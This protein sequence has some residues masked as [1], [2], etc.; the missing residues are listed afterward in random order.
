MYITL[1]TTFTSTCYILTNKCCT[2]L[3]MTRHINRRNLQEKGGRQRE[4]KTDREKERKKERKK[5]YWEK[6]VTKVVIKYMYITLNTT[7][8]S[9]CYIL[10]NKCCT[11][12]RMTRHINRRNLQ[13]KRGGKRERKTDSEKERKTERK[14]E[15]KKERDWDKTVTKMVIKYMYITLN[16]TFTSTCYILTNKCCTWLRMTRHINR[17]NLQEKGRR[18]RETKTDREKERK[19]ER[20]KERIVTKVSDRDGN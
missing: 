1:N 13:G 5:E 11:W 17:R 12:L 14:E 3:R 10:T 18:Q 15:R 8:T 16:T 4:T 19:K 2:W 7:F 6:S 20:K 9:T